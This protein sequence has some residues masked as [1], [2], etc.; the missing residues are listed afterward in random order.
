MA[1][2]IDRPGDVTRFRVVDHT[3]DPQFFIHFLNALSAME[4]FRQAKARM[5]EQLRLYP[6]ARVLDLGCGTGDDARHLAERVAPGGQVVGVDLSEAMVAEARRRAEGSGLA[7]EFRQGDARRLEFEDEA[8]DACRVERCLIHVPDPAPAVAEL[9]RLSRPGGRVVAYDLDV[10]AIAIDHPDRPLTRRIVTAFSEGLA[11]GQ[12]GRQLPALFADAG[13]DE[14]EV[15][16]HAVLHWPYSLFAAVFQ[17][18]LGPLVSAGQLDRSEV[19]AWL[20]ALE[21]AE[22]AGRFFAALHGFIVSG[23]KPA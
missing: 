15:V 14:V 16:P 8:F 7:V 9:V 20:S 19:E 4:G 23:T 18:T 6:G 21:A 11:C 12:V 13:L 17:G 3:E 10:D 2:S 1:T 5:L 22:K